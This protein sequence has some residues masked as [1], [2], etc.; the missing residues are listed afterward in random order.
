MTAFGGFESN[1]T[2]AVAVSGGGD[3]MA[4]ALLLARWLETRRGDLV[5][6]TVDHGLRPNS[7]A[8]ARQV[9]AWLQA[10]GIA[11]QT[12]KW[13]GAKPSGGLQAQA[14]TARYSL[15]SNYCRARGILHLALAHSRDDQIETVAMRRAR[16]SGA[17]GLAAMAGRGRRGGVR[18]L[19][20][21]LTTDRQ[22]LRDYLRRA[23][24]DWLEDPSNDDRR[25]ERV[26]R[27]QQLAAASA[28]ASPALWHLAGEAGH[29]RVAR[30]ALLNN[31]LARHA[32]VDP[33]GYALL[34]FASIA[35]LS[36]ELRGW[37]LRR[38]LASIGGGAYPPRRAAVDNL[39]EA[40]PTL[41]VTGG[42]S[43]A[44]CQ[45]RRAGHNILILRERRGL[46]AA[47]AAPGRRWRAWDRFRLRTSGRANSGD[48]FQVAAL[49]PQ[50]LSRLRGELD[51][52]RFAGLPVPV[53]HTL[54][55]LFDGPKVLSIPH[56][57]YQGGPG[58]PRLHAEFAPLYPIC[59]QFWQF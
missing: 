46:P 21:L 17:E 15:L 19:R 5:G 50:D 44:H 32:R 57:G 20:P 12:L 36:G 14:R 6:L 10:R 18:L 30:D 40:V 7:A 26:R 8:E 51:P 47:V 34:D 28:E 11:H 37:L 13:R 53:R 24:Q 25:Y 38:V 22:S 4:L 56:L 1:P 48:G 52:G 42:L 41:A 39:S 31:W 9:A 29:H 35:D 43:L 16:G 58:S 45:I 54:P 59:G 33:A 27:R 2:I 55:A 3:S 23:S 49:R